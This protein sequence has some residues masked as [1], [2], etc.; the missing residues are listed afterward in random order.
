MCGASNALQRLRQRQW[1]AAPRGY[2][3]RHIAAA[4][5]RLL[6]RHGS[7]RR[8]NA[9]QLTS[10][11]Y[12]SRDPSCIV[13]CAVPAMPC[14]DEDSD[15]GWHSPGATSRGTLLLHSAS[16]IHDLAAIVAPARRRRSQHVPLRRLQ[17][18]C[19]AC[20]ASNASRRRRQRLWA[21]RAR[22]VLILRCPSPLLLS[23]ASLHPRSFS[24][25][26][27]GPPST[28]LSA[29]RNVEGAAVRLCGTALVVDSVHRPIAE[30]RLHRSNK[31]VR[32]LDHKCMHLGCG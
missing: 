26:H 6:Q 32:T 31:R 18:P 7:H 9:P 2:I 16:P 13:L 15:R 25:R 27:H 17:L 30:T 5:L 3:Q 12:I 28:A 20:G 22:H 23:M 24:C 1:A 29:T 11:M 14:S 4:R 21:A 19:P 8:T 10:I